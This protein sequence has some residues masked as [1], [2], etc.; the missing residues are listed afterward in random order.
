MNTSNPHSFTPSINGA[1]DFKDFFIKHDALKNISS[2]LVV[3]LLRKYKCDAGCQMCYI[4]HRWIP[5]AVYNTKFAPGPITPEIEASMLKL[6]DSFYTVTTIDD[7]YMLKSKYPDLYQFYVKHGHRMKSA[8]M[9][10]NAFLQQYPLIMKEVQFAGIY[11][12]SFSD[13]LLNKKNGTMVNDIVEMLEALNQ[14]SP[15]VKIKVIQ[16]LESG[17]ASQA[18]ATLVGWAHSKSIDV[19]CHADFRTQ[20][21]RQLVLQ[22]ADHQEKNLHTQDSMPLMLL[23]EVV[24]LVYTDMYLTCVDGTA[25]Q[26]PPFFNI[27]TDGLDDMSK[28]VAAMLQSKIDKYASYTFAITDRENNKV[29]DYYQFVSSC[30]AVNAAYNFIPHLLLPSDSRMYHTI[31]DQGFVPTQL[32]LYKPSFD[33]GVVPLF[34]F[35]AAQRQRIHHIPI[36]CK[37]VKG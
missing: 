35:T 10:D 13:S 21:N 15:V 27:M 1:A 7:L 33:G 25:E 31:K 30:V 19:A 28:F 34:E 17:E 12:I 18:V 26:D 2:E 11:E 29:Y 23:S 4:Q 37:L 3:T 14:R 24:R 36:K 32:G 5:D 6:F 22:N 8:A 20:G 9:S 16:T